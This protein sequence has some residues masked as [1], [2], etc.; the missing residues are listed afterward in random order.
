MEKLL[1]V[2]PGFESWGITWEFFVT[3]DGLIDFLNQKAEQFF[4]GN[5]ISIPVVSE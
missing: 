1:R 3:T 2:A 4:A 5:L